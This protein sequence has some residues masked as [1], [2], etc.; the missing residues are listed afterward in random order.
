MNLVKSV[1]Q[2]IVSAR[3]T[4]SDLLFTLKFTH[5]RQVCRSA[6]CSFKLLSHEVAGHSCSQPL[7]RGYPEGS[8]Q[9][10]GKTWQIMFAPPHGSVASQAAVEPQ[11]QGLLGFSKRPLLP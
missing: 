8:W 11:C 6:S 2:H 4:D 3:E 9:C 5:Q 7:L 1:G 10:P